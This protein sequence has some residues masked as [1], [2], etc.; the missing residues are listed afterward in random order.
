MHGRGNQN[1][2]RRNENVRVDGIRNEHIVA[3]I[4][5]DDNHIGS[6]ECGRENGRERIEIVWTI[7]S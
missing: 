6:N 5:T 3:F 2:Y 7:G 4:A 1:Q